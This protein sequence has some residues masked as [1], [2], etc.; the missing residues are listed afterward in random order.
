MLGDRLTGGHVIAKH[1]ED[2]ILERVGVTFGAHPVPDEG[3]VEGCRRIIELTEDL[4]P[5]DLV[6]TMIGNGI[7]SLLTYPVEGVSLDDMQRTV[8]LFQIERGGPTIDLIP[9]RNHL[10]QIKGGQFSRYLQPARAIHML[11]FHTASVRSDHDTPRYRWLHTLPDETTND[12]AIAAL[13][14]W[15]CWDEAPASV[16]DVSAATR[17]RRGTTLTIDEFEAMDSR[18]FCLFPK[19]L[20]VV[21]TAAAKAR[22]MGLRTH[23]LFNN[24]TMMAEAAQVGKVV[25]NLALHSEIDGEPFEPPCCLVGGGELLVTVGKDGGMG[26]RN[27]EYAVSAARRDRG[28]PPHHHGCGGLGRHRR[29]GPSVRGGPRR[30]AGAGRRHRG[31]ADGCAAPAKSGVDLRDALKRHDTSPAL[32]ALGD[33]SSSPRWREHGR[34][35]RAADPGPQHAGRSGSRSNWTVTLQSADPACDQPGAIPYVLLYLSASHR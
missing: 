17:T 2:L 26:G 13:K 9:I 14:K 10:D 28:L 21:N 3:C 7:G 30:R 25:A 8:H 22:E 6:I 16:R 29:A 4:R 31:R 5:D 1:G 11:A 27:Q 32:Y 15:D 19:E 23:V 24:Y 34:S 35:E 33:A 18:I 20:A 12:D